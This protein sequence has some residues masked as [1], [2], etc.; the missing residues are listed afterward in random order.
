MKP[1]VRAER[2][3][4]DQHMGR[5]A[6]VSSS[7]EPDSFIQTSCGFPTQVLRSNGDVDDSE[8]LT[9]HPSNPRPPNLV[10]DVL[11]L[12]VGDPAPPWT[13][14]LTY[15]RSPY[16]FRGQEKPV[17]RSLPPIQDAKRKEGEG[18]EGGPE[19]SG[20]K[21]QEAKKAQEFWHR[22][23]HPAQMAPLQPAT[24]GKGLFSIN[25]TSATINQFTQA[26]D[27]QTAPQLLKLTHKY[28]P[29]TKQER[30]QR[31]LAWAEKKA[32]G[33]GE[34]TTKRPVL[35]AGANTVTT[36]V[37]NKKA[38]LVVIAHVMDPIELAVFLPVLCCK[39]GVPYCTIK[40]KARL[41][42]LV[43]RK[44]RTTVNLEDKGALAKLVECIGTNDN[45]RYDD[46]HCPWRQCPGSKA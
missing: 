32:E 19:A 20:V 41:G 46:I 45:D 25:F 8:A 30:K 27:H 23:G 37:D 6:V 3:P 18:E 21:K 1:E 22:T 34:V 14:L 40:G 5:R 7:E 35:R 39:M 29:E 4:R 12:V 31:L 11:L 42:H 38:Q 10:G 16:L 43:H 44:I 2:L 9:C 28:R 15:S 26:L 13:Q 36:L 17:E 24:A 33:K